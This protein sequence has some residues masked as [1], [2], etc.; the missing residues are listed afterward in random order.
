MLFNSRGQLI[1]QTKAQ[2]YLDVSM[3]ERGLILCF[4]TNRNKFVK[5][6]TNA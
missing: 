1:L 3:L 6:K 5:S 2:Y 4:I